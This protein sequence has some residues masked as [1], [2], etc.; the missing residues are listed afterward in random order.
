MLCF[1]RT[2]L[3][4]PF[5]GTLGRASL[6]LSPSLFHPF[7]FLPLTVFTFSA[8]QV[9]CHRKARAALLCHALPRGCR[10]SLV[11]PGLG[12]GLTV[13]LGCVPHPDPTLL[14]LG[15]S[16]YEGGLL[17]PL[18]SQILALCS[19]SPLCSSLPGPAACMAHAASGERLTPLDSCASASRCVRAPSS[20]PG[21]EL[22]PGDRSPGS[23]PRSSSCKG[24]YCPWLAV[25]EVGVGPGRPCCRLPWAP[26]VEFPFPARHP[27]PQPPTPQAVRGAPAFAGY[28][29]RDSDRHPGSV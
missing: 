21:R 16:G 12:L 3:A 27:E 20:C 9:V 25:A 7:L 18:L 6:R 4:R 8:F 11:S 13:R 15:P 1:S 5:T 22:Q 17:H 26:P 23:V 10:R 2:S 19:P 29:Q 14:Y 24:L 28:A